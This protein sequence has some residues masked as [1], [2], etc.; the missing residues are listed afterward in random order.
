MAM[1]DDVDRVGAHTLTHVPVLG[2][3]RCYFVEQTENRF[4]QPDVY[5]LSNPACLYRAQG[6]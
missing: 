5:E 2:V 1:W 4:V 6:E 3:H